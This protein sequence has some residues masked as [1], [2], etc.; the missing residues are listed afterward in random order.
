M[1]L[2]G[3]KRAVTLPRAVRMRRTTN[4]T[5]P[6]SRQLLELHR[7]SRSVMAFCAAS[8]ARDLLA[9]VDIDSESVVLDVGAFRGEW[10]ARIWDR[11]EPTI[12]CFEP[13]PGAAK[14]TRLTFE[15]NSKIHVHQFGLGREDSAQTLILNGPGSSLHGP[16]STFGTREVQ[17]RDVVGA[18]DELGL[19]EVDL[20]KVNIEG[21]EYDLLDRLDEADRLAPTRLVLVQFHEWH[22]GAYRRRQR[23]RRALRRTHT[24]VWCYP[25]CWELWSRA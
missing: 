17:I 6:V 9:E 25:W 15:G 18:L 21:G 24:E 23:N 7:Y 1:S 11:Y 16:S 20:L 5:D 4:L 22:P 2:Y 13:L 14:R 3:L 8:A 12:H 10:A 19:E